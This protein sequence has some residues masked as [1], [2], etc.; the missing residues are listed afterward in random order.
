MSS[1][2]LFYGFELPDGFDPPWGVF[3]HDYEDWLISDEDLPPNPYVITPPDYDAIK[4]YNDAREKA[5]EQVS[6]LELGWHGSSDYRIEYFSTESVEVYDGGNGVRVDPLPII[7]ENHLQDIRNMI[8]WL[9]LPRNTP[10]GWF[11][12]ARED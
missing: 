5:I 12:A 2:I 3:Q 8:S 10:V 4:R 7:S 6:S 9:A 11:L 1:A